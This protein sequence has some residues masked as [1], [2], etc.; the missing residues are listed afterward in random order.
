MVTALTQ[1]HDRLSA[2]EQENALLRSQLQ[3]CEHS[4]ALLQ[5]S[6]SNSSEH[7]LL[8][9]TVAAANALL[10]ISNFDAA[11][12]SALQIIG[13]A[14]D[15]DRV[16]V[17][18]NFDYSA[19]SLFPYWRALAY[20]WNSLGTVSQFA[21]LDAAQGSYEEIQWLYELFQ[22][23]KAASYLIEEAPEPF[24]SA[25]AAIGVKSTHIVPISV[26]G[27]W[28]G[29]LGIDDCRNAKRRSRAELAVLEIAADCIGSA[30]QRDRTQRAILKSE[31]LRVAE[32][33]A[34]N[35]EL[36]RHKRILEATAQVANALLTISPFDQAVNTA[37]QII[38]ESLETDRVAVIE[39][40]APSFNAASMGW[41]VLYEWTSPYAISQ[42]SHPDLSQGTWEG[43]EE[44][45]ERLSQNQSISFLLEEMPEPFRSGQA[46]LGL[47]ALYAVP[48]FVEGK[49]WGAIG[50]D[51]CRE[52]ER[53]SPAEL[54]VLKIAADCI[55]SAIQRDRTQQAILEAEQ[56]RSAELQQALDCLRESEERFRI[57]FEL[58]SEGLYYTEVNPPCP[59][60]L[61]LEEQCDWLYQNIQVVQANPAFAAMYGADHPDQLIGLRN[62]DVHVEGSVKNS[63]FIQDTVANNYRF[64]NLETEEY[65]Q[66]GRQRYFLNSGAYI[67][68]DGYA[69]GAWATQIDITELRETQQ[70]L[71]QVEQARSAELEE[72][73]GALKRTVDVLAIETDLDRFLGQV[74]QVIADQLEAPLVEYW[75]HP[76]PANLAYVGL[77]YWQGQI[78]K[79]EEQPGHVGSFGYPVPSEM[80]Q[81][82]S[83]HHRRSHFTIEDMATS[84]LLIQI[85]HESGLDA[86]AWYGSRGVSSLLNVPLILGDKTIGALIVFF[87]RSRHFTEQQIELTYA[88]AQQVTLAVQ[89]TRLAEEARQAAIAREQEQAAQHQAA[90]LARANTLLRNSLSDLSTNPNLND[91]LGHLL[92]EV[93]RY[94]GASVG[95]IFSYDADQNTLN[96]TIRC[97]DG[98]H[99]FTPADT[100]PILFQSPISVER[101]LIFSQLCEQPR[102]AVL[103]QEDFEGRLWQGASEWF[104]A[105]GYQ[106]TSACVLMVG[107]RPLG[108]L[109]MAFPQPVAFSSVEEELVL[110]LAQ[111]IALVLQLTIL[112]ESDKQAAL[113]KLN[114]VLA[115][116]QEIAAQ[117]RAAELAKANEALGRS[118]NRL[119][120][121]RNLDSFLEHVLQEALQ[122]LH[123]AIAQIFTYDSESDT[124]M[125]SIAVDLQGEALPVPG[126]MNNLPIS[127]PFPATVTKAWERM[128]NQRSPIY[129]D[130]DRDAADYWPGTLDWH[131]NMGHC[132]SVCTAL[133]MGDRPLGMLG[134]ALRGRTKFTASEFEFF[135]ALGQ[136]ATLAMQMSQL[137]EEARQSAILNERNRMAS[138]IHDTLAQAFTGISLQIEVA[139]SLVYGESQTVQQILKHISQLAEA[140]LSEARR[141][142]WA[143]H[144]LASEYADLAQLLY[145]SVE[146]MTRNTSIA[147]EVNVQ[148]SP[149]SLPPFIGMNLLRIGQEAVT[150]A[151]KHAQADTIA[152]ELAYDSDRISLTIYDNGRGFMPPTTLDN[153]N[154]GFGLISMY[155]RCDRIG[156]QLSLSSQ[157]GQGTQIL[158]EAPLG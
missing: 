77:T 48:V 117:E 115:R 157:P 158:V 9:A 5:L 59:I 33:T 22:Q 98:Q 67:I 65:Y 8:E 39:N 112:G 46:E 102:L 83:L 105:R 107:D 71:L 138:E 88:F 56:A 110:A 51:D 108:L 80:I 99:F 21:D 25:Q 144:P 135:Q 6:V 100:E 68:K 89:L 24:R 142:V 119:A 3:S 13:G 74:L 29:V 155:E 92:V 49:Y 11:V 28:W 55:G 124:L 143:L 137:A 16:N 94:S 23:G 64:R 53:R 136:Q 104:R 60:D 52:A 45:Y 153:I 30:I 121:E 151:L 35:E 156:A 109:A 50:F 41:K 19:D 12:N 126:L 42:I 91:V 44:W 54:S 141:S 93:V 118:L 17:I 32:L 73:N 26:E 72:V 81:Q 66:Q 149:C 38:G 84:P 10:T 57:L 62:A 40:F 133:M 4:Y 18:E 103:N 152:I 122:M 145:E 69:I 75:Y 15:G 125:A 150:N 27:Q 128:L 120:N 132:G 131:R 130:L 87:P 154:G 61:P 34:T 37:L 70:A 82:E 134:L 1:L 2:L 86:G 85:A 79:P 148:G 43:I 90:E 113:A 114:E 47:K 96:L 78:L 97:Q 147:V 20:E 127:K 116:E 58:S 106:G 101:T 36:Q 14:L 7:C 140:G 123:G 63:R 76:E 111:Q 95:H 129:F 31:Q 139:K 146:Q